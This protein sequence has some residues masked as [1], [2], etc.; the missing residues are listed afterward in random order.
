VVELLLDI[1]VMPPLRSYRRLDVVP[2]PFA[3][4]ST[5]A[6]ITAARYKITRP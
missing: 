4:H 6:G 3:K 2:P 5:V 1:V